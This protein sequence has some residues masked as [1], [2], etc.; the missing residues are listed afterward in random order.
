[1]R[2][3]MITLDLKKRDTMKSSNSFTRFNDE[4]DRLIFGGLMSN[5]LEIALEL[6]VFVKL[7]EKNIPIDTFG[8]FFGMS[9]ASGRAFAQGLCVLKLLKYKKGRVSNS[10]LSKQWLIREEP[11]TYARNYLKQVKGF[12]RNLKGRFLSPGDQ[13]W[14]QIRDQ[15][16]KAPPA[17]Y[18]GWFH[19]RR[20]QWGEEL[21]GA[22][23]FSGH[24]HLLDIGG[25]SGGWCIGILKKYPHLK[26]CIF[27]I[28]EACKIAK[29]YII[30]A[31]L[32][33]KVSVISGSFFSDKIPYK[34]DVVLLAN[35]LH[36]WSIEDGKRLLKKIY[37]L[38]LPGGAL[39]IREFFFDDDYSS[40]LMSVLQAIS[41]L[42]REEK[43]GW[44]PTYQETEHLLVEQGFSDIEYIQNLIIGHKASR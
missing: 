1:M 3:S 4:I 35:I 39:L 22:Y 32:Q 5:L 38:L 34:P 16:R 37:D 10:E 27:D 13:K 2:H 29:R 15:K 33:D 43:S 24:R 19:S 23:D 8:G 26:C 11:K 44:Q 31:G 36:D 30:D 6:D 41:V 42:G 21:A 7:K 12:S 14:Y 28:P 40:S 20:I 9:K 17:F 18:Q 25:A